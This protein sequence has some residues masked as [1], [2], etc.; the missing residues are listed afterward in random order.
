MVFPQLFLKVIRIS[1]TLRWLDFSA[2]RLCIAVSLSSNSI[3]SIT[4][5]ARGVLFPSVSTRSKITLSF[6]RMI[7]KY[8]EFD[9]KHTTTDV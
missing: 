5:N 2:K 9:L 6:S 4:T 3:Q 8:K 7:P 1:I